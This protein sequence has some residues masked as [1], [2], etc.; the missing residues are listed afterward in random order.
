MTTALDLTPR[1]L[2]RA[3][4]L[5][6]LA[7]QRGLLPFMLA[8]ATLLPQRV[9]GSAA[10]TDRLERV[11]SA[12]R[13]RC[14]K[15]FVRAPAG[16]LPGDLEDVRERD[17]LVELADALAAS[18]ELGD[19]DSTLA[20][21]PRVCGEIASDRIGA[22][23]FDLR[24]A[25]LGCADPWIFACELL[26]TTIVY[27]STRSDAL[28]RFRSALGQRLCA[29]GDQSPE[30]FARSLVHGEEPALQRACAPVADALRG[31]ASLAFVPA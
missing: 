30:I 19:D 21:E 9:V 4:R 31:V 17:A 1:T 20:S 23:L 26:G 11:V 10:L 7:P 15:L 18:G 25:P 12:L 29:L 24:A 2:S 13:E 3:R 14:E 6:E 16:V 22:L 27:R 5:L 8:A 28:V